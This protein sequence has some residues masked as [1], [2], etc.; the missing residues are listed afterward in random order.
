MLLELDLLVSQSW[1]LLPDDQFVPKQTYWQLTL[2]NE[3]LF[4]VQHT[5]REWTL[6]FFE[7]EE[8][9]RQCVC[10]CCVT[11]QWVCSLTETA[12]QRYTQRFLLRLV[13]KQHVFFSLEFIQHVASWTN[14]KIWIVLRSFQN[15][16]PRCWVLSKNDITFSVR[17]RSSARRLMVTLL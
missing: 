5:K 4:P 14:A 10:N 13:S 7:M 8:V 6:T 17:A 1:W 9:N 11:L 2:I 15:V 16:C 12:A 3:S